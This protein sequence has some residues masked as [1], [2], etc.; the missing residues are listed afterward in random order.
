MQCFSAARSVPRA[1]ACALLTACATSL[2][3]QAPAASEFSVSP[4]QMQSLGITLLKLDQPAAIRGM[5]YPAKVVLPPDQEQVVSA[6]VDGVVDRLLV[7]GQDAITAG[8]PLLR[9]ASS[10]Y[11]ELQLRLMEAA[12]KARL[13]RTTLARERQLFGEGIIPERRVQEAEAAERSEG[14]RLRQAEAALRLAGAN[15]A[16]IKRINDGNRLDDTLVVRA[17][18]A[19]LVLSIEVKPGQRVKEADA[20][21]RLANLQELWLDI[22]VPADRQG[23]IA[24]KTGEIVVSGRDAVATPMSVGA[25]VSDNQTV[26]LRA[27]VTRGSERLRPGEVVQAQVP[28]ANAP[29]GW[30]LPLQAVAR[31]DDQAYVFV[32]SAKGFVATPVTVGA[33]AGQSVQVTGNLSAGQEIATASVIALK[34]AWLGKSGGEK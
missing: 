30:A 4:A 22:Q 19:G 3:G 5:A 7:S 13:S 25:M 16:T 18:S 31:Q 2:A 14:A 27:R 11:G 28:F 8:Q 26:T 20:L 21:V 15:A 10:E 23:P 1:I 17:K 33:S 34:A 12:A 24:P 6:P 9:L 29:A 32:R